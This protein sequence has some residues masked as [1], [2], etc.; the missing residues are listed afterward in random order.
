LRLS[1]TKPCVIWGILGEA[2]KGQIWELPGHK[3]IMLLEDNSDD[4]FVF[5]AGPLDAGDVKKAISLCPTDYP[6]I[7]CNAPR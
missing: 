7:Y 4:P 1:P 3:G 6:M 2:N 5:I